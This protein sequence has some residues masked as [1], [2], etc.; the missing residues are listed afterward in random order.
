MSQLADTSSMYAYSSR[1]KTYFI[2]TYD[3]IC[4]IPNCYQ[5]RQTGGGGGFQS[6]LNF[7]EGG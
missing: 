6:P 5:G 4:V 1:I 2:S 3:P 7:G